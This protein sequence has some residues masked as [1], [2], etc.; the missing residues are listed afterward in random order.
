MLRTLDIRC[1][2]NR[3]IR[4]LESTHAFELEQLQAELDKQTKLSELYKLS[5]AQE[6]EK[7]ALVID[8]TERLQTALTMEQER[9]K[10]PRRTPRGV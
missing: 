5:A 8:S 1:R 9:R 3:S 6:R 4:D 10:V 7:A 2:A